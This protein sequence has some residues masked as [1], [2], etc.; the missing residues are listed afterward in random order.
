[1][2]AEASPLVDAM[3]DNAD[4]APV[5]ETGTPEAGEAGAAEAAAE[6]STEA[7]GDAASDAPAD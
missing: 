2:C 4:A 1:L 3:V 7:G 5:A 6:G